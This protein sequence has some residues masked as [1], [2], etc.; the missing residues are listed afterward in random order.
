MDDTL[1]QMRAYARGVADDALERA[2]ENPEGGE[3]EAWAAMALAHAIG[4]ILGESMHPAG[5]SAAVALLGAQVGAGVREATSK[6]N[7]Q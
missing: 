4:L 2:R 5:H 6:P 7:V 1:P 3:I